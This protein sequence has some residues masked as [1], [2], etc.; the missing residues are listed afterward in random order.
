MIFSMVVRKFPWLRYALK[1]SFITPVTTASQDVAGDIPL[2]SPRIGIWGLDW[3]PPVHACEVQKD[4]LQEC[5]DQGIQIG[6][7]TGCLLEVHSAI[8]LFL[9]NACRMLVVTSPEY[10]L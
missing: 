4:K 9:N 6:V 8:T 1:I 3:L 5:D 10:T 2:A 7:I